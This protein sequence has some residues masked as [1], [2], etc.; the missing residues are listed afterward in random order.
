MIIKEKKKSILDS[1]ACIF[2]LWISIYNDLIIIFSKFYSKNFDNYKIIESILTKQNKNLC[3]NKTDIKMKLKNDL[4]LENDLEEEDNGQ[5]NY[6]INS[7]KECDIN[8]DIDFINKENEEKRLLPKLRFI[9]FIYNTFYS[10]CCCHQKKQQLI[11]ACNDI[12]LEY[13]SI[14]NILYNQFMIENLFLD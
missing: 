7:D 12:I 10:E 14:E 3:R 4:L 5:I 11:S 13:Y 6:A 2:S 9:D 8:N 1:F